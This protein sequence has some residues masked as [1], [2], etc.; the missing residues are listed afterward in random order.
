LLK[1]IEEVGSLMMDQRKMLLVLMA[2]GEIQ[3]PKILK[4]L[5]S[6]VLF[7]SHLHLPNLFLLHL[8]AHFHG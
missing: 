4:I 5:R 6:P 8:Q 3:P 1:Q 2:V 7:S